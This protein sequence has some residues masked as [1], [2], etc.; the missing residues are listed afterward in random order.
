V[1]VEG[2]ERYQLNIWKEEQRF[3]PNQPTSLP[4]V[5]VILRPFNVKPNIPRFNQTQS[6]RMPY[7][8]MQGERHGIFA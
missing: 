4:S 5:S 6:A 7:L 1:C 2:S 3:G 8:S